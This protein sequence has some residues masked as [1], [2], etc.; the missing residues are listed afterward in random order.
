M[1]ITTD[2]ELAGAV[3]K[4][5]E[6]IQSIFDYSARVK[7]DDAKVRFPRGLIGTAESYRL[8][9]PGYLEPERASN[10]AYSFMF[11]DVLWWLIA[12]T[13]ITLVAKQMVIK[14]AIVTL[15]TILEASLYVPNLPKTKFLSNQ[16]NAGIKDRVGNTHNRGWISADD[17]SSL[18]QLWEH[19]NNVHQKIAKSSE[20][21][22]YN[23]DHINVP[24]AALLKLLVKLKEWNGNDG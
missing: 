2:G 20:L 24:H 17:C 8:R 14:S 18:K 13:D 15:G 5:G 16:S 23:V 21:E 1:T 19:R 7:R 12:R 22:L 6:L 9:L 10:C 3:A 4:C 11:V